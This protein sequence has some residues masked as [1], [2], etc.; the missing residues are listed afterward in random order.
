M[1]VGGAVFDDM[2]DGCHRAGN[3]ASGTRQLCIQLLADLQCRMVVASTSHADGKNLKQMTL[4]Y[5]A[6]F[7]DAPDK[8][9]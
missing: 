2:L 4:L 6:E 9:V 1:Q 7:A 5:N 8:S 3:Y